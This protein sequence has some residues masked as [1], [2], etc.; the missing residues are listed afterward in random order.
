[1][2]E[3]P[4]WATET[5]KAEQTLQKILMIPQMYEEMTPTATIIIRN[6]FH[7]FDCELW[8]KANI[9]AKALEILEEQRNKTPEGSSAEE[10]KIA[11]E[12]YERFLTIRSTELKPDDFTKLFKG[13]WFRTQLRRIIL[14]MNPNQIERLI[15]RCYPEEPGYF[16][17]H[18]NSKERLLDLMKLPELTNR[19][20]VTYG[21]SENDIPKDRLTQ[22]A[23]K[24]YQLTRRQQEI[25]MKEIQERRKCMMDLRNEEQPQKC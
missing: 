15:M 10:M 9:L 13:E 25:G 18:P 8:L 17:L 20:K 11:Y 16:L 21:W 6:M 1:M 3:E 23:L 2:E 12:E 24:A 19:E 4:V 7:K 22:A 5:S 14:N